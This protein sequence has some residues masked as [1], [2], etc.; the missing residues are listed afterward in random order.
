M[1]LFWCSAPS[2]VVSGFPLLIVMEPKCCSSRNKVKQV[3]SRSMKGMDSSPTHIMNRHAF[4]KSLSKLTIPSTSSLTLGL[5]RRNGIDGNDNDTYPRKLDYN[6]DCF[7]LISLTGAVVLKDSVFTLIFVTMSL[8]GLLI[9]RS[10]YNVRKESFENQTLQSTANTSNK[11]SESFARDLQYSKRIPATVA[12]ITLIIT[13]IIR[14]PVYELATELSSKGRQIPHDLVIQSVD[15]MTA[16][17]E[18]LVCLTSILY[19]FSNFTTSN[20]LKESSNKI[21]R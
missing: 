16:V 10:M 14:S 5:I 18:V 21:K 4:E 1:F 15:E 9:T 19:G 2:L 13:P 3:A 11:F 7:G 20:K 12:A 8:F 17:I 6:D